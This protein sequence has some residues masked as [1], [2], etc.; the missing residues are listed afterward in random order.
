MGGPGGPGGFRAFGGPA[1]LDVAADALGISVDDLR[2]D[3]QDGQ[4]IAEVAEAQGVDVQT[5]ID[6]LV[7]DAKTHLD[8]AV[9]DGRITQDQAD[10]RAADLEEH[11]TDMVNGE[12][13]EGGPMGGGHGWGGPRGGQHDDS[14]PD[15]DSGSTGSGS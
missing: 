6:A 14:S 12:L 10:E 1:N 13:P 3:L 8:Q 4:T 5:V 15:S 11:I 7:A 9:T 2:S